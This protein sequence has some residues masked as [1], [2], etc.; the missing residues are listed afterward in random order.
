LLRDAM[1][2][3][4]GAQLIVDAEQVEHTGHQIP[5]SVVFARVWG[6][7]RRGPSPSMGRGPSGADAGVSPPCSSP[8]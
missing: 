4:Y 7:F 2:T 6:Q 8:S 1:P 5:V 3:D